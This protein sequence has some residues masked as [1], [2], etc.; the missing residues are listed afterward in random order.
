MGFNYSPKIVTDGLVL[1]LDAANSKSYP[2]SGTT[3]GDLS[4]SQNNGAL[5]NSP[6]FNSANG[7]SIVFNGTNQY[8][9][10]GTYINIASYSSFSIGLTINP[11]SLTTYRPF[12]S[13][14][15][16]T[17]G[18]QWQIWAGFNSSGNIYLEQRSLADYSLTS[19]STFSTENYYYVLITWNGVTTSLYVNNSLQGFTTI[20]AI[21]NSTKRFNIGY[22]PGVGYFAGKIANT[23]IYNRALTATEIQQNYNATKSR[24]G[25]T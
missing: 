24:F 2:G 20:P 3:W 22:F 5:I 14:S 17:G 21:S 19:S 23:Q 15:E 9:D 1:Y 12:M 25:L 4:R 10:G 8:I 13:F 18:T 6:T 11:S 16:G 7:G